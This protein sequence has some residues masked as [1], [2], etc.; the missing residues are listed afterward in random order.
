MPRNPCSYLQVHKLRSN[1][2]PNR[3][4]T[5]QKIISLVKEFTIKQK[6]LSPAVEAFVL[7]P[8]IY[9][10]FS[11]LEDREK[12][13]FI[14]HARQYFSLY[15]PASGFEIG[16][17]DRYIWSS[18]VEACIVATREYK[19]GDEILHLSGTALS[20]TPEEEERFQ[21]DERDFSIIYSSRLD[22]MC[23]F[24]GPARLINHDCE[25]NCRFLINHTT[26]TMRVKHPIA[27]GEEITTFYGD[28]YFGKN[29]ADCL[30]ATCE[31][32]NQG[33]Y[34]QNRV[35]KEDSMDEQESSFPETYS[36]SSSLTVCNDA[37][38]DSE[39]QQSR[40][41]ASQ[42]Y[43][44]KSLRR[45]E[46]GVSQPPIKKQGRKRKQ[47]ICTNPNCY[48]NFTDP[49]MSTSC[50]AYC[51]RCD[52]HSILFDLAW[53]KRTRKLNDPEQY[54]P[55]PRGI[56]RSIS[57]AELKRIE[58]M[59]TSVDEEESSDADIFEDKLAY[60][61]SREQQRR[62]SE[63]IRST[64]R[65][66]NEPIPKKCKID[67]RVNNT[68]RKTFTTSSTTT[69][70]VAPIKPRRLNAYS[71]AK[72]SPPKA[73]APKPLAKDVGRLSF[74]SRTC[75][76]SSP[77]TIVA[78]KGD[79]ADNDN[80]DPENDSSSRVSYSTVTRPSSMSSK[81]DA[82][83]KPQS[84]RRAGRKPQEAISIARK[85]NKDVETRERRQSLRNTTKSLRPIYL[86]S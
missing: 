52:R 9:P 44:R 3:K 56:Y 32:K 20:M 58:Q 59:R 4:I 7:L 24:L 30:C 62:H 79:D 54:V 70:C 78:L 67:T 46:S 80:S 84:C 74:K 57:R 86:T 10:F 75:A 25:S 34:G 65:E 68:R 50:K 33:G 17:T 64:R 43:R 55:D 2:H 69:S 19:A 29:N 48:Q 31:R 81:N 85:V 15:L 51:P 1:Y 63:P 23:L 38:F 66:T 5:D 21:Q 77:D 16:T 41:T 37:D 47:A 83:E 53:P 26:V 72:S 42:L 22:A 6:K 49:D 13:D 71:R 11:K 40:F 12:Q 76:L 28:S 8:G 61:K 18:K 73:A 39:T 60:E 14:R 82:T 27:V 45:T 36:S 35:Q